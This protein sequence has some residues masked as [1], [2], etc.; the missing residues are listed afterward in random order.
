MSTGVLASVNLMIGLAVLGLPELR[1]CLDV[2]DQ[3]RPILVAQRR[4]E[5]HACWFRRLAQVLT[6]SEYQPASVP[7]ELKPAHVISGD[8][9]VAPDRSR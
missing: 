7:S 4:H 8:S 1:K 9:E 3:I 2:S 5:G 6:R